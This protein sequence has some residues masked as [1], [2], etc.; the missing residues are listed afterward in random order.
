MKTII[1][2]IALS[3]LSAPALAQGAQYQR[4]PTA[5]AP[6]NDTSAQE[7]ESSAGRETSSHMPRKAES[8]SN[9]ASKRAAHNGAAGNHTSVGKE[10]STTARTVE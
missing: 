1:Y 8:K 9:N 5:N 2:A 10:R 6:T 7:N 3:L 4:S